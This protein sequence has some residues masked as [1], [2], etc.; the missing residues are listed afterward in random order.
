[1]KMI[2]VSGCIVILE[3]RKYES[4]FSSVESWYWSFDNLSK[5]FLFF[6]GKKMNMFSL[7][8]MV[9][10]LWQYVGNNSDEGV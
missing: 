1:M 10:E 5:S 9:V 8:Y 3:K 6:F 7:F 2:V 4:Y